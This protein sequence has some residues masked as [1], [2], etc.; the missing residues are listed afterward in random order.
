MPRGGGY[1]V[2]VNMADG[3]LL[4]HRA[5]TGDIKPLPSSKAN[6]RIDLDDGLWRDVQ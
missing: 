4:G 1:P 2:Q 6:S 5:V 3:T